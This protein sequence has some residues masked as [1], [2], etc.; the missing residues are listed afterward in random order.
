MVSF[1]F[2]T[3]DKEQLIKTKNA[4]DR[5]SKTKGGP[6]SVSLQKDKS[7]KQTEKKK[8]EKTPVT[9]KGK[10]KE[11]KQADNREKEEKK[12]KSCRRRKHLMKGTSIFW[13]SYHNS[14]SQLS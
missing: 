9:P 13:D 2:G 10:T 11:Q 4:M 14:T 3:E 6:S 12:K 5:S 7:S 8:K 1:L